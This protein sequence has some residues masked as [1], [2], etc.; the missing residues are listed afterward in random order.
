MSNGAQLIAK[1]IARK[2]VDRW[3]DETRRIKSMLEQLP[4]ESRMQYDVKLSERKKSLQLGYLCWMM[5]GSH[6]L[7]VKR[8]V[9]QLIFWGTI[10]GLLVWY[11]LDL[12]LMFFVI[13]RYNREV[14]FE[15]LN[16]IF[17]RNSKLNSF[18]DDLSERESSKAV[19][20][21]SEVSPPVFQ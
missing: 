21:D 17:E 3:K 15:I 19:D 10:G 7:Y 1:L 11:M 12:F 5:C 8:P 4:Q 2:I 14:S 9:K 6:Y 20:K 13:D 16:E 18:E